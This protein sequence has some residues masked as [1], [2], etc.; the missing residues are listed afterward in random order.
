MNA[1]DR[2]PYMFTSFYILD[3]IEL[4]KLQMGTGS[5]AFPSSSDN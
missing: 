5:F 2:L 3:E 4:E 1:W